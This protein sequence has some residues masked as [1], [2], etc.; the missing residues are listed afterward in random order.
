M[1]AN[2]KTGIRSLVITKLQIKDAKIIGKTKF[3]KTFSIQVSSDIAHELSKALWSRLGQKENYQQLNHATMIDGSESDLWVQFGKFNNDSIL[4]ELSFRWIDPHFLCFCLWNTKE[5]DSKYVY[6]ELFVK[7]VLREAFDEKGKIWEIFI[8]P[9]T[10][11]ISTVDI[12]P[13]TFLPSKNVLNEL[14]RI[15]K[16][17]PWY[18]FWDYFTNN[19]FKRAIYYLKSI[20]KRKTDDIDKVFIK[21][22]IAVC[23]FKQ[24]N[25]LK[26]IR[27]FLKTAI[28]FHKLRL[29]MLCDICIFFAIE[30]SKNMDNIDMSINTFKTIT[31]RIPGISYYQR[32]WILN[33]LKMYAI[34]VN[35][36][37]AVCCRS[38]IEITLKETLNDTYG[39]PIEKLIKE[40]KHQKILKTG[41]SS[42]L[43]PILKVAEWKNIISKDEFDICSQIK[44]FGNEI[45]KK[46]GDYNSQDAKSTIQASIHLLRQIESHRPYKPI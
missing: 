45:H 7:K 34:S 19:N 4:T 14:T 35:I 22:I 37:V 39:I 9:S 38:L 3:N 46:M 18:K 28:D 42:G 31:R 44:D 33:I 40:C 13:Q 5:K 8:A 25:F 6:D 26:A 17:N 24:K 29:E 10:L 43:Y 20:Q 32:K 36:G 21:S 27:L 23:Y 1:M 41:A 16:N 11:S 30:A 2:E 12:K 15:T